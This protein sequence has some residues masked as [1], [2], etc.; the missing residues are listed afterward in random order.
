MAHLTTSHGTVVGKHCSRTPCRVQHSLFA[1]ILQWMR[2]KSLVEDQC[3]DSEHS[4]AW[5]TMECNSSLKKHFT[6][7]LS[8]VWYGN[9]MWTFIPSGL[10]NLFLC[11][12]INL[13][14]YFVSLMGVVCLQYLVT[15]ILFWVVFAPWMFPS[16]F[17][18]CWNGVHVGT[19]FQSFTCAIHVLLVPCLNWG[20][21]GP[22]N[23][24]TK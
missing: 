13:G 20:R 18:T 4:S 12:F 9:K 15:A 6:V 14:L 23:I 21:E 24:K 5:L 19:I 3:E 7:C 8:T 17:P 2:F 11:F 10:L 16:S 22:T 1:A